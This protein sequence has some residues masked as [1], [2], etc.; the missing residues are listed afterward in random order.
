MPKPLDRETRKSLV[1]LAEDT[2]NQ[3]SEVARIIL[4]LSGGADEQQVATSVRLPLRIVREWIQRYEAEG[5]AIFG[6]TFKTETPTTW[7]PAQKSVPES[8]DDGDAD[9]SEDAEPLHIRRHQRERQP[10]RKSSKR[11]E[12]RVDDEDNEPENV[13]VDDAVTVGFEDLL[14]ELDSDILTLAMPQRQVVA[15]VDIVA[16][17]TEETVEDHVEAEAEPLPPEKPDPSQPI[18]VGALA[19]AFQVDM[20]HAR[21]I[22]QLSR[23]LFDATASLH[24]LTTN[25][26][27]LLHAGALLHN[28]AYHIDHENHHI[29]GRDLI[30]EYILKDIS[31]EERQLIAVMTALH[32]LDNPPQREKA[33]LDLTDDLRDCAATLSAILKMGI[34]FDYSHQQTSTI[35]EWREAP[36]E[37]IVVVGG[38]DAMQDSARAQ[39]KSDLWN[40]IHTGTRIRF[41]TEEQLQ[42]EDTIVNAPPLSPQLDPMDSAT[43]VSTKLRQHFAARLD[44]L[45]KRVR[46]GEMG[47]L[48][49]LWQEFQRLIGVW[50]W[51]LPGTKPRQAFSEDA[52]WL[53]KSIYNALYSAAVADRSQGLL[54][55]TDPDRD[56][57]NAI[58]DLQRLADYYGKHARQNLIYLQNALQ[59]RRY[60]R[61]L[62]GVKSPLRTAQLDHS[63]FANQVAERAWTHLSELRQVMD[64]IKRS[65]LSANLEVELP[66]ETAQSFEVDLRLMSDILIYSASLLGS[67]YD[68]VATIV[69]P[70]LDFVQSW[71]RAEIVTQLIEKDQNR[72]L[73]GQLEID[74]S[75]KEI[76]FEA[77]AKIMRER[78]NEMRYNLVD[79][80]E[81]LNTH[82]FR[83]AFALAVAKP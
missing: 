63:T 24:R 19:A 70:L 46:R 74:D 27:D 8:E 62:T 56:D 45:V 68:Q 79:M 71:Q 26:R 72:A 36:G 29:M 14:D 60:A 32:R 37:I 18:S 77:F 35:I 61:W 42:V 16:A 80:W 31:D 1:R 6:D 13:S 51:L 81:P 40:Q 11:R 76:V 7:Q 4:A 38:A 44:Y 33:Y 9:D 73:Q 83:R 52:E 3:H 57:P 5:L 53:Q 82:M 28:I 64:R 65:G 15:Q 66:V 39:L 2:S 75:L 67:E 34:G 23:E 25:Y 69:H 55:D 58:Q 22:S 48:V 43:T 50:E 41:V 49:P 17:S 21:H 20:D 30:L 47:L 59:S 54:N 10:S 12:R 78:A